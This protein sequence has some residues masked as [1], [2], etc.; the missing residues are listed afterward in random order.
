MSKLKTNNQ[1]LTIK[2][3]NYNDSN[4]HKMHKS[5]STFTR[6]PIKVVVDMMG[7]DGIIQQKIINQE[8][9]NFNGRTKLSIFKVTKSM[10]KL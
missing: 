5:T 3:L 7:E 9:P 4:Q 6:N 10:P 1:F 2:E 8:Q